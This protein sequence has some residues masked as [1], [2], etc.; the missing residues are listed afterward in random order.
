VSIIDDPRE[1]FSLALMRRGMITVDTTDQ[2]MID[3]CVDDLEKL[4]D[5]VDVRVSIN[6]YQDIPEG[7]TAIAQ[8]WSADMITGAINY[9]PEGTDPSVL[10]YWHPPA[11]QYLV[12]NDNMAIAANAENPVL[13][14]LYINH[15]L[16]NAVAEKN[17]SWLGYLPAISQLDGDYLVAQGYVPEQ[18]R[19]CVPT[20]KDLIRGLEFHRLDQAGQ[21]QYAAA[22]ATFQAALT[23]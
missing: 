22:W 7:R 8:T 16:D 1:A 10:G 17:F 2:A 9:L 19:S 5:L 6:A 14:H 18:L 11:H 20:E 13:A 23:S 4:I 15:L 12:N 21:A 3:Q